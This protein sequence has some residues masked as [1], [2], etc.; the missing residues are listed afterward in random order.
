MGFYFF[1]SWYSLHLLYLLIVLVISYPW[2]S[3]CGVSFF[4]YF[5]FRQLSVFRVFCLNTGDPLRE[6]KN[7]EPSVV[8]NYPGEHRCYLFI[9]LCNFWIDQSKWRTHFIQVN[10]QHHGKVPVT[11]LDSCTDVKV[12]TTLHSIINSTPRKYFSVTFI[13]MVTL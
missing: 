6:G 5:F 2:P 4:I 3:W 8:K 12:K 7:W 11:L 1:V 10:L 9:Y 13:W